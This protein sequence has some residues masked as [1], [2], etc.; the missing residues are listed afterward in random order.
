MPTH[1]LI[2]LPFSTSV[3]FTVHTHVPGPLMSRLPIIWS[4]KST[5]FC[6]WAEPEAFW[7]SSLC[8]SLANHRDRC[9]VR[10]VVFKKCFDLPS[11]SFFSSYSWTSWK[12][13]CVP[14]K[15]LL[16]HPWFWGGCSWRWR[17]WVWPE[18]LEVWP[19]CSQPETVPPAGWV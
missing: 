6:C 2:H 15:R 3:S 7:L 5:V 17:R 14:W 18:A 12:W 13:W 4:R 11:S 10:L 8:R 19:V 16:W 9:S 1:L